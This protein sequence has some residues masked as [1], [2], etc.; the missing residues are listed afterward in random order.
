MLSRIRAAV[1]GAQQDTAASPSPRPTGADG[2]DP[3]AMFL[4]RVADYR[5]TVTVVTPDG[6]QAAV[7]GVLSAARSTRVVVPDD[8]PHDWRPTSAE[9]VTDDR[10]RPARVLDAQHAT[11]TGCAVAIAE[12]GTVILDSGPAQGRRALTLLPDHH[13]CVV[14]DEQIVA[15]VAEAFARLDPTRPITLVSGPSATSDIELSRIE[16]VHGPRRLD[17]LV[18]R[19]SY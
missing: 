8:L 9:V 12:T 4:E 11:V 17:I 7:E 14:L 6:V 2:G 5:A 1:A 16:G 19:G 15:G 3:V 10:D 13:V 18:V